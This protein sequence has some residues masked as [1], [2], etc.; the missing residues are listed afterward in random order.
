MNVKLSMVLAL[1]VAGIFPVVSP[2]C[3]AC[4]EDG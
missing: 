4:R 3:L 2:L 1:I